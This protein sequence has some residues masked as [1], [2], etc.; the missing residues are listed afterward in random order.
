MINTLNESSLHKSLK[1][2]YRI[3]EKKDGNILQPEI[4]VGSFI[5]DLANERNIVEIQG[6]NLSVLRKKLEFFLPNY[7]VK[8]VYPVVTKKYIIT[9]NQGGEIVR[10][11]VSP[12]KCSIYSIFKEMTKLSDIIFHEN[13][14]IHGVEVITEEIRII[15]D[16]PQQSKNKK[17]RFLQNWQK[18]DKRLKEIGKTIILNNKCDYLALLEDLPQRENFTLNDLGNVAGKKNAGYMKYVFLK[19]GLIE[20]IPGEGRRKFF[21]V[22]INAK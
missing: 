19:S 13:L 3:K 1:E 2:I 22:K 20:E 8:V 7:A 15:T 4:K 9:I 16:E 11:T 12:K 21:K 10:E 18:V 6:G 5:C 14:E 17:R